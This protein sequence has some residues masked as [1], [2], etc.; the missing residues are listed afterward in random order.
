MSTSDYQQFLNTKG[1][2]NDM[3][4]FE[5]LWIPDFLYDFQKKLVEWSLRKGKAALFADCGLGKSIIELV[6]AK[7]VVRKTKGNIL[8]LT[9]L[10][11]GSQMIKE[12]EFLGIKERNF[13]GI[14]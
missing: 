7:N 3:E 5:P 4:G 12:A 10:A 2:R 6:W 13:D 14:I 8:L 1:I 9:P 11:V